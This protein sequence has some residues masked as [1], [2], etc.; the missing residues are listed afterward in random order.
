MNAVLVLG[1]SGALGSE[2]CSVLEESGHRVIRAGR[3]VDDDGWVSTESPQWCASLTGEAIM[4][5]V[6]AAGAN[7]NNRLGQGTEPFAAM[8]DAN[9][10]YVVRTLDDLL[11]SRTIGTGCSLV[12][13]SSVWEVVA[14]SGKSAYIT[15]KAAVGGFVRAAAVELGPEGIRV[16]AVLPGVV[17]TRMTR[18]NLHGEQIAA[19]RAETPLRRLV[20]PREVAQAVDWFVSAGSSGV[21]GVGLA[22]DGGWSLAHDI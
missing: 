4:G 15:S 13:L 16:N 7:T 11:A 3:Q 14:R 18:K 2:I 21:S 20:T 8:L 9:L 1:A 10:G 5:V 17:D 19:V 6:W 12:V 22:V